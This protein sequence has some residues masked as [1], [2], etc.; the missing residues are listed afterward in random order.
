MQV[1]TQAL[2][3]AAYK[4]SPNNWKISETEESFLQRKMVWK[5]YLLNT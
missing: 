4:D 2:E 3:S 1:P 5:E